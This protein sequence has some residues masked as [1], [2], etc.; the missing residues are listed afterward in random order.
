MELVQ[1]TM[2]TVERLR[3][4]CP[5]TMESFYDLSRRQIA[6]DGSKRSNI[7]LPRTFAHS[8][9]FSWQNNDENRY[10]VHLSSGFNSHIRSVWAIANIRMSNVFYP[11]LDLRAIYINQVILY[12]SLWESTIHLLLPVYSWG[13]QIGTNDRNCDNWK[14]KCSCI[15]LTYLCQVWCHTNLIKL[16]VRTVVLKTAF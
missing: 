3:F 8:V 1:D 13:T 15:G 11:T 2:C 14:H 6:R 16:I 7:F 4:Y 5:F 12:D 10:D 9:F